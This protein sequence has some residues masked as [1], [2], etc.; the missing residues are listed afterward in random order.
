LPEISGHHVGGEETFLSRFDTVTI[1]Y[2]KRSGKLVIDLPQGTSQRLAE[3]LESL[4]RDDLN[5][6]GMLSRDSSKIKPTQMRPLADQISDPRPAP[7]SGN[8]TCVTVP[9]AIDR[10]M[11]AFGDHR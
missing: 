8:P 5:C 1:S 11:R 10:T 6:Q 9:R 3:Q 4:I 7:R 2:E